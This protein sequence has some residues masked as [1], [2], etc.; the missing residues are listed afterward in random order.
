MSAQ[1]TFSGECSAIVTGGSDA[2]R[3]AAA[4]ILAGNLRVEQLMGKDRSTQES[5][6]AGL[7]GGQLEVASQNL[8]QNQISQDGPALG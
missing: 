4:E 7:S 2:A 5:V 3:N 6:V 8:P 1:E